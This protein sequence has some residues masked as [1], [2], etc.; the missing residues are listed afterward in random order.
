MP[1]LDNRRYYDEFSASYE[2]HRY[3][4]YH[5]LLDELETEAVRRYLSP[6]AR[7]LEVGCGT[8]LILERLRPHAAAAFG[9]DLSAGML[10][11]ARARQLQVV[12]GTATAL[13]FA[14]A[15]FDVVC[16]FKV[17]AHIEAI[18]RTLA[19]M[20]R[21]LRPGG[22]L[23]AEFYN[24]MSLRYLIKR[25]KRPTPISSRGGAGGG[26][27]DDEAVYTRYDS[28]ARIRSYLPPEV[29]LS[30]V[31]GIRVVTPFSQVHGWPLLGPLLGWV[32]RRAADLP[33]VRRLGG[34]LLVVARKRP[35]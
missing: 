22:H 12:Q 8:G 19:E 10:Q 17:L 15:S 33:G 16:S 32:E 30:T 26:A 9:L 4:G 31:R 13:P 6:E 25:L 28:L 7:V 11:K 24:P 3:D 14:D 5:V 1:R 35:A 21:V 18:E 27:I 29:E 23:L 20:S 2:R 34:F